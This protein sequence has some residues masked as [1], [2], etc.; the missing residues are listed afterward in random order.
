MLDWSEV[1]KKYSIEYVLE[2][3]PSLLIESL[4]KRF[5]DKSL[6]YRAERLL[7]TRKAL[8]RS[9]EELRAYKNSLTKRIPK[10]GQDERKALIEES[11]MI[12]GE[13]RS[14]EE[15][16]A[17]I[18]REYRSVLNRIPNLVAPD[19]P[20]AED[21]SGNRV[22]RRWGRPRVYR[23]DLDRF[24][25]LF[26]DVE[27]EVIDFRPIGHADW[28]EEMGYV[29]I[30]RAGRASGSR[31]YYLFNDLVILEL[32]LTMYT[33]EFLVKRGYIPVE[34]PY[35]V[36]RRVMEGAAFFEAFEEMLYKV[37]DE[38]LYLIATSEQ[39]IAGLYMDEVLETRELP[40]KLAG[41]SPCFRREAGAHGKDTKGIFRVHQFN[42]VEQF[43]FC[44]P[45]QS[46]ELHEELIR[47]EEEL[48]R[49]LGIPYQVVVL[50]SGDMNRLAI[51][52]YDLEAWMPAQLR[53]RELCSA[54]NCTDWQSYRLNIRY[55]VE[56]GKEIKGYVHTLNGTAMAMQRTITAIIEN[57][58]EEDGRV[59]IPPVLRKYLDAI[60]Y[61]KEYLEPRKIPGG[62]P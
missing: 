26:P 38:D 62:K 39:S 33:M 58:Q 19:V 52:Q 4:E 51:K 48:Y 35:M 43:I 60:G 37:C 12:D 36:R 20:V 32:A 6:A 23:E 1:G 46:E 53:Y 3:M 56:R 44:E 41:W 11:R 47:N 61:D 27:P 29:D 55:A 8:Q 34:P 22:V 7:R 28:G 9:L 42:K 25:E 24:G 18:D 40:I 30:I 31:F 16:I 45:G 5:M 50:A 59:R 15:R 49:G 57:F 54:S 2:N 14:L 21:E 17:K 13:I 10:A